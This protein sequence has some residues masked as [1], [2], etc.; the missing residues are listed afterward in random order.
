MKGSKEDHGS[1]LDTAPPEHL[2][3]STTLLTPLYPDTKQ[4]VLEASQNSQE[5]SENPPRILNTRMA[6]TQF[7]HYLFSCTLTFPIL[8]CILVKTSV[9]WLGVMNYS[10][11]T[12]G[13][14]S[15]R[16]F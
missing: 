11:T 9:L 6:H 10:T 4:Q 2:F 3:N 13:V 5:F 7:K 15:K 14:D 1:E 16:I 8:H 12:G